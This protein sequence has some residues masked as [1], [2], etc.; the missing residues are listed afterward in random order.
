VEILKMRKAT[1]L[2][3]YQSFRWLWRY[4]N[5]AKW[6][7]LWAYIQGANLQEDVLINLRDFG[8]VKGTNL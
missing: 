1:S 7:W 8:V 5:E 2:N 4:D 3:R 6:F